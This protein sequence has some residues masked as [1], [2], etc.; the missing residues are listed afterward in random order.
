MAITDYDRERVMRSAEEL[1]NVIAAID[2]NLV[3]HLTVGHRRLGPAES[4]NAELA[5]M[6]MDD[7]TFRNFWADGG[8]FANGFSKTGDGFVNISWMLPPEGP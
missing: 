3:V 7:R 8:H 5:K 1:S 2:R 4:G 6:G